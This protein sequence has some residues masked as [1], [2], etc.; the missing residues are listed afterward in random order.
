MPEVLACRLELRVSRISARRN[1]FEV[2][3]HVVTAMLLSELAPASVGAAGAHPILVPADLRPGDILLHV[4]GHQRWYEKG[5]ALAT[6]SPFTHA[7]I[8]VGG[9]MIAEARLPRVRVCKVFRPMRRERQLC[10]LRQ[11]PG[12]RNDQVAALHAFVDAT[13]QR[14]ARFDYTFPF[15]F[16]GSRLAR[17][18]MP[19]RQP[20]A[21]CGPLPPANKTKYFCTS[22][23]VDAFRAMGLID[24]SEARA[25]CLG[26]LSAADL[27]ADDKFGQVV[28]YLQTEATAAEAMR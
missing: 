6:S 4:P 2:K 17:R 28:G 1:C 3:G 19:M 9:N 5:I 22:F 26:S 21:T 7:S 10:I 12:L 11:S 23:V 25:Y 27:L 16:Y 18:L 15:I 13:L 24:R 20:A 14:D 8:Y